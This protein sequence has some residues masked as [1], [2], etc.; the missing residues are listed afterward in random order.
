[1]VHRPAQW[2]MSGKIFLLKEDTASNVIFAVK[3]R[4][5]KHAT[6]YQITIPFDKVLETN[7]LSSKADSIILGYAN[8]NILAAVG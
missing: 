3:F 1:M 4:L 7:G 2:S 8:G 6:L 5:N